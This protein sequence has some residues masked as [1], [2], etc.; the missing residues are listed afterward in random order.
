MNMHRHDELLST[1]AEAADAV[2]PD[3]TAAH[4]PAGTSRA[5]SGAVGSVRNKVAKQCG[6]L[7]ALESLVQWR[8]VDIRQLAQQLLEMTEAERTQMR[9][10]YAMAVL[11]GSPAA[12]GL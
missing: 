3:E 6:S 11:A 8:Q 7:S 10:D 9:T 5:S 4:S 1:G 2:V 12:N